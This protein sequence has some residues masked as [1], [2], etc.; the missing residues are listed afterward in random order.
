M[1]T[2]RTDTKIE[3]SGMGNRTQKLHSEVEHGMAAQ[4]THLEAT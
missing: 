3:P 1:P 2:S 4:E